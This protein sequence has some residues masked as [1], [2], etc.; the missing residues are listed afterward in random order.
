MV[1]RKGTVNQQQLIVELKNAVDAA[2]IADPVKGFDPLAR[3]RLTDLLERDFDSI[4]SF[5][6]Q[7]NLGRERRDWLRS[8]VLHEFDVT[9]EEYDAWKPGNPWDPFHDEAIDLGA[10]EDLE[11]TYPPQPPYD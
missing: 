3:D 8:L 4:C 6:V 11:P 7:H 9:A 10:W 5:K 2:R 1:R